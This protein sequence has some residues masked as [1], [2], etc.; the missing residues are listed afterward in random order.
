[1]DNMKI[2][3][4]IRNMGLGFLMALFISSFGF[5]SRS[6]TLDTFNPAPN[7]I[8]YSAIQTPDGNILAGGVFTN[9]AGRY[10]PRLAR[11]YADGSPEPRFTNFLPAINFSQ[12]NCFGYQTNGQSWIG[13]LNG[14]SRTIGYSYYNLNIGWKNGINCLAPQPDNKVLVAGQGL[15]CRVNGDGTVD[16]NFNVAITGGVN[17]I[18]LQPDGKILFKGEFTSLAGVAVTNLARLNTDGTLDTNF[19]VPRIT[20]LNNAFTLFDP[21]GA[22]LVQPDG[23]ILLGGL[24]DR[25]NGQNHTNLVRLN[26]DGS[27]DASFNAQAD[28]Y[29]C[30]GVQS[31]VM[32][33]DGKIIVGNDSHTLNGKPCPY[34]GRLN[35]D[36]TTDTN[37]STNLV[38][39]SMVY[40]VALQADGNI[41]T[42]GWFTQ[43]D[44]TARNTFGRLVNTTP[45]TQSLANDGTNITWLRGGSSPEVWRT[46]FDASTDA[47]NWTYLGDGARITGGWQL[48]NANIPTNNFIRARGFTTGGRFNG[49]SWFVESIYPQA[50]PQFV[51]NDGKLG[52]RTNQFGGSITGSAGSCVVVDGSTD[53]IHWTPVATNLL[54][55]KPTYFSDPSFTN[56]AQKFYRIRLPDLAP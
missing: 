20:F 15:V 8:V 25:V 41:L 4:G 23:K 30:W 43:L 9:I 21:S 49:S 35:L 44:G 36:G 22:L 29:D 2:G 51:T 3:N 12:V 34:L 11:L 14:L 50:A 16:T 56:S 19:L 18:A 42:A 46:T 37:F 6:Q 55:S 32:Q 39:G 38:Y 1:M 54:F 17:S 53:L 28:L 52:C 45:A 7:D 27:V 26:A 47:T 40:S 31:L 13:G 33:A 5:S 48:A 24:F 10:Y